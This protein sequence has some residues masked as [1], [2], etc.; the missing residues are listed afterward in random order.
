M[1][2]KRVRDRACVAVAVLN[3]NRQQR[4]QVRFNLTLTFFAPEY[5]HS[6]SNATS[7]KLPIPIPKC[8]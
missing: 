2:E 3:G 4:R 8:L 1:G 7:R 5:R 6:S